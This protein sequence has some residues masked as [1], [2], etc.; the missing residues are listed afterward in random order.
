MTE[1]RVLHVHPARREDIADLVTYRPAVSLAQN[2]PFL[3]MNHHGPQVFPP[4]NHGLPFGPHPHRGFETVT[5]IRR[6][7][8]V[9]QDSV[10]FESV[11]REGGVQWMTAGSGLYHN[12]VVSEDFRRD[13]GTSELLQLWLNLPSRLK[14]VEPGYQGAQPEDLI[15]I[16][17]DD[18]KVT[19]MLVAGDVIG[20]TGPITSLTD[21]MMSVM[22]FLPGGRV[23]LPVPPGRNVLLYVVDGTVSVGGR[24]LAPRDLAELDRSGETVAIEADTA[25]TVIFGHAEP[26][27]EPIAA[28]GPFVMNTRAELQ[29]AFTDFQ[30]G[31]VSPGRLVP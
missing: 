6:G 31:K 11:I 1:R 9:H 19:M 23:E 3:I 22:E 8:L 25:A 29:Q 30:S 17:F 12:E 5:F 21:T 26:I 13:G 7:D 10:G 20:K 15:R 16:P 24:R 28:G 4:A 2:D 18:G 27:D 14:M